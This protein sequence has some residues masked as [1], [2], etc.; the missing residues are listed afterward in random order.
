MINLIKGFLIGIANII[1]GV[2]GGTFA[3][4]L[5]IFDRLINALKA[6]DAAAVKAVLGLPLRGFSERARAEFVV[7]WRRFDGTFLALLGIGALV[8]LVTCAWVFDFLLREYPPETLA[9]F[10]GLIV[11]SLAVPWRMM[12]KR[13]PVQLFWVLPGIALTVGLAVAEIGS[14]GGQPGLALVFL[15]GI[16]AVS[17]MVLPGVSGSFL[18]LVLGL[19]Q[20][21][22]ANIKQ[23][24]NVK[25]F[26]EEMPTE[27]LFFL[28]ALGAGILVGLVGFSHI[29]SF[30]LRRFRSATLAF[31]IGLILG[32][33]WVLW[34]FKDYTAGQQVVDSRGEV[35]RSIA[36]A[37]APNR[38]P[39]GAEGDA[40]LALRCAL[41]LGV[42][43]VGA[44]GVNRL[45]KTGSPGK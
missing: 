6:L 30:L 9:F 27:P 24:S 36:V 39:G 12:E 7:A 41:A 1:P 17:A 22:L 11:P 20:P 25:A 15:G 2:S 37:T 38:L 19:Y 5:G 3:L 45:G 26:L 34:P 10:I 35:K 42:G 28:G 16:L 31:L 23:V 29:M 44:V 21:V 14:S 4:V 43:L 40:I 8:A 33:F 32:S 18:L 13:G